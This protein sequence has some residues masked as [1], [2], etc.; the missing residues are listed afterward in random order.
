MLAAGQGGAAMALT[1]RDVAAAPASAIA[2]SRAGDARLAVGEGEAAFAFYRRAADIRLSESLAMRMVEAL[3]RAGRGGEAVVLSDLFLARQ[4][5]SRAAAHLA[6][7]LAGQRGDWAR[8]RALL[9]HLVRTGSGRDPRL[10]ADLSLACLKA[11]DVDAALV[12]GERA[13]RLYRASPAASQAWGMALAARGGQDGRA[14]ALL[15]KARATGGD[16]PLLAEALA[17]LEAR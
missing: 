1:A 8:A 9:D 11:G 15:Q 13:W 17:T 12:T 3:S 2:L 4:P 14:R 16:N 6:A 5:G 7:G 10:L